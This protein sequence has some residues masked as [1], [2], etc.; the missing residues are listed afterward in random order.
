MWTLCALATVLKRDI[1]SLYPAVNGVDDVAVTILNR[2]TVSPG[3]MITIL[4][5][6][7]GESPKKDDQSTSILKMR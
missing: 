2:K 5:A 4:K 3:P 6:D 7:A 1:V